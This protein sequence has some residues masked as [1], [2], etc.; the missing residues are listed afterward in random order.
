M[1]LTIVSVA[2]RQPAV[3]RY[4][5]VVQLTVSSLSARPLAVSTYVTFVRIHPEIQEA[6]VVA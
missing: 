4:V 1:P 5:S 3:P 6:L 2:A